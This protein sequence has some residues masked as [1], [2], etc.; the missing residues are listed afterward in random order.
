MHGR[1]ELNFGL[2]EPAEEEAH[3]EEQQEERLPWEEWE[4]GA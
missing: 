2:T 3:E 4:V 1:T